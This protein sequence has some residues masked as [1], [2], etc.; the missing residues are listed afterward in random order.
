MTERDPS[1]SGGQSEETKAWVAR[2]QAVDRAI[3]ASQE[4]QEKEQAAEQHH[5]RQVQAG[6]NPIVFILG[7]VL[8]FGV[9]ALALWFFIDSAQCD[10]MI[11]DRGSS[12]ACR[13]AT[14]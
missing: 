12:A 5:T 1:T 8:V 9:L 13:R 2:R 14:H 6:A 7:F 11:T 4:R 10:P 3:A